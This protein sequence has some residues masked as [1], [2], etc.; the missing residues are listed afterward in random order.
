MFIYNLYTNAAV[1]IYA[2]TAS[3]AVAAGL[4][5]IPVLLDRASGGD[6]Y[7]PFLVQ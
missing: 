6:V 5:N 1:H 3:V 4:A 2:D 7:F